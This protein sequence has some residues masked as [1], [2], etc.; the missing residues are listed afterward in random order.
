MESTACSSAKAPGG[1]ALA[2][3]ATEYGWVVKNS[4]HT[5]LKA[6]LSPEAWKIR[7]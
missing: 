7:K 6:G 3:V 5:C 2:Q 4:H 1:V